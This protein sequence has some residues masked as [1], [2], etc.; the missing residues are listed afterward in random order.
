MPLLTPFP[1]EGNDIRST[2]AHHL[3]DVE[4]TVGLIGDGDRAV[5][6]LSLHLQTHKVRFISSQYCIL[7]L[8]ITKPFLCAT[9]IDKS[10]PSYLLWVAEHVAFRT[11]NPQLQNTS[12]LLKKSTQEH[13]DPKMVITAT[14]ET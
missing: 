2:L 7:G 12:L 6:C 4:G 10:P 13:Y 3:G 9:G 1:G 14:A 11:R 8:L 5:D